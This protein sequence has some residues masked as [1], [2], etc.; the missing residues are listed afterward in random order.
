MDVFVAHKLVTCPRLLGIPMW[1]ILSR[2]LSKV[3]NTTPDFGQFQD[4]CE[5][6][7]CAIILSACSN[8][9]K[10]CRGKCR[11]C[12]LVMIPWGGFGGWIIGAKG[13]GA[14]GLLVG[15]L[16][17]KPGRLQQLQCRFP[18]ALSVEDRGR[19]PSYPPFG[20]KFSGW[21]EKLRET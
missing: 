20:W 14:Q 4:S 3:N 17:W 6:H 10:R 12:R 11:L 18:P 16:T 13:V 21:N 1:Q 9:C 7:Q 2:C 8:Q 5:I 15:K 19:R